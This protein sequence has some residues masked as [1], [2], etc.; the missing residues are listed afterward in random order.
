MHGR[1]FLLIFASLLAACGAAEKKPDRPPP[2]V[3]VEA[4]APHVFVDRYDAVGTA[5]ANEQ[6]TVTAPVTERIVRLGFNDG[7]FVRTG[8]VLAVLA[9]GQENASLAGATAR[10]REAEQQLAR[11]TALR[12]RGFAT[13]ASLDAQVATVTAAREAANE[14]RAVIADRVIRAPF[15]GQVSLRRISPGAVVSAGT[16]IATISDARTIKLDFAVPETLL[17]SV[18]VGQSIRARAAAFPD[19]TVSGTIAAIDPLVD[20]ATR[21]AS[22]RALIRNPTGQL[23]PGMLLSVMLE[24]RARTNVAVSELALVSEGESRFVYIIG[25]DGK[26]ARKTVTTGARDGALIEVTSGLAAGE[27]IVTEG[28]VKLSEGAKVRVAGDKPPRDAR[29]ER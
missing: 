12:D 17:S 3:K 27:K 28:V 21:A 22:V 25:A 6:V 20:P 5:V 2:L 8:Q 23:K 19:T 29:P 18:R 15:S 9:Q 24:S 7:D 11:I 10:A 16:E 26:A 1:S 13:K 4:V 14:A